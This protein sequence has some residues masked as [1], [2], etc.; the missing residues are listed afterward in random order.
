MRSMGVF[1][2]A[3]K[4][5]D[6]AACGRDGGAGSASRERT[7]TAPDA[8][9]C[10]GEPRPVERGWGQSDGGGGWPVVARARAWRLRLGSGLG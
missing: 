1:A 2:G 5:H 4:G 10:L 9:G 8:D 3:A 7:L 6:V